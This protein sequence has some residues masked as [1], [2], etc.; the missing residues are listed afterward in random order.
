MQTGWISGWDGGGTFSVFIHGQSLLS[1][2]VNGEKRPGVALVVE[3]L[4]I[5]PDPDICLLLVC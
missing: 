4:G 1:V 3:V 5:H 2:H